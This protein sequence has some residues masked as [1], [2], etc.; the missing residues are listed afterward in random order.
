MNK[1]T[2]RKGTI[3]GKPPDGS[4]FH[5]DA[6]GPLSTRIIRSELK[7]IGEVISCSLVKN[8]TT[9]F[10]IRFAGSIAATITGR[11]RV[12]NTTAVISEM[13]PLSSRGTIYS[14]EFR[15]WSDD[16]IKEE[17]GTEAEFLRRLP[18]KDQ[19]KESSGRLLLQFPS[20]DC[21]SELFMSALGMRL[22][23]RLYTPTPLRCKKCHSY[24]HHE[25]DCTA[26]EPRCGRC[27]GAHGE[28]DCKNEE[29]CP[30]CSGN[31]S[32]NS[33]K[34]PKWKKEFEVNKIRIKN[35]L[36]VSA[37]H[38]A[39]RQ[40]R[41][42]VSR[43][44]AKHVTRTQEFVDLPAAS[45]WAGNRKQPPV[46]TA[47]ER[48]SPVIT[49]MATPTPDI[50]L[51]KLI[52]NQQKLLEEIQSQNKA[53]LAILM[54]L[55]LMPAVLSTPSEAKEENQQPASPKGSAQN[56]ENMPT[57][58]ASQQSSKRSLRSRTLALTIP[59]PPTLTRDLSSPSTRNIATFTFSKN[60]T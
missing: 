50:C 54:Q 35:H 56:I 4:V 19:Q 32:V 2:P 40:S 29:K 11:R 6:A 14:H 25:D 15:S 34:C 46:T 47:I 9:K 58:P 27:G 51:L 12:G 5:L 1:A 36:S 10:V 21:P 55:R 45:N 26:P 22:E 37:A 42:E 48:P 41:Q 57:T 43:Q 59:Q 20:A 38:A 3:P 30:A 31:H 52:E 13:A 24:W 53:I 39:Y 49:P 33:N 8:S 23:V 28:A 60:G 18:T 7:S 44:P 17:L 16:E